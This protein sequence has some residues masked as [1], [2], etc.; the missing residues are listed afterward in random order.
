[1]ATKISH[2]STTRRAHKTQPVLPSLE[3]ALFDDLE[4]KSGESADKSGLADEPHSAAPVEAIRKMQWSFSRRE[5]FETCPLRYYFAYYGANK[6]SAKG[7]PQKQL[8]AELKALKN[9]YLRT[10]DILHLVIKCALEGE[11]KG[12][13]WSLDR[14]QG[15]AVHIF[16]ADLAYSRRYREIDLHGAEHPP[17]LLQEFYY[18]QA[19]AEELCAQAR[20]RM[21]FDLEAFA[22]LPVYE[23]ARKAGAL[24]S[25]LREEKVSLKPFPCGAKGKIDLAYPEGSRWIIVDWKSGR[26]T[27]TGDDSLQLGFYA[28]WA[29]AQLLQGRLPGEDEV[30][31]F[32]AYLESGDLI[33]HRVTPDVLR[34]ARVRILQDAE[35]MAAMENY[36]QSG[37]REA[38]TPC[39]SPFKCRGC[40]FLAACPEGQR[41]VSGEPPAMLMMDEDE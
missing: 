5:T 19:D 25:A 30:A 24:T 2:A 37:D 1:V 26:A 6:R 27:A 21:L 35:R 22:T 23:V 13:S 17:V 15:F 10:G 39:A 40:P 12:K 9:R 18:A 29:R 33:S 38:F 32:M 36:G 31:V 7:E 41:C 20:K 8:L 34:R 3:P 11:Q 4:E 14:M 16:D 28:L